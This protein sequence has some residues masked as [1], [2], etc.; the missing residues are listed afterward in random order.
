MPN[1]PAPARLCR[2][3]VVLG[4]ADIKAVAWTDERAALDMVIR[5]YRDRL[6]YH[7]LG[8]VRDGQ[9]AYDVVQEVFIRAMRE[10]RF[11]NDTSA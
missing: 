4:Q 6:F 3:A 8:I 7:A 5:K 9:E 10:R 2:Q 11:F 1:R